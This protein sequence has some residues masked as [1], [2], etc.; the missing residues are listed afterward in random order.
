M[1]DVGLLNPPLHKLPRTTSEK[2]ARMMSNSLRC[3]NPDEILKSYCKEIKCEGICWKERD[4]FTPTV[5]QRDIPKGCVS[6][7]PGWREHRFTGRF[8]SMYILLPLRHA[9][10]VWQ[11]ET[12]DGNFPLPGEFWHLTERRDEMRS[13]AM[14]E[15]EKLST[16]CEEL[17]HQMFDYDVDNPMGPEGATSH[18]V[19]HLKLTGA[20]EYTPQNADLEERTLRSRL[21]GVTAPEDVKE[22]YE[23]YD[24]VVLLKDL[25][26][27]GGID[28]EAIAAGWNGVPKPLPNNIDHARG[29]RKRR[30]R[31][32]LRELKSLED[33]GWSWF[34]DRVG[35]CDGTQ[36]THCGRQD[37]ECILD[38]RHD[39]IGGMQAYGTTEFIEFRLGNVKGGW[40]SAQFLIGK[41]DVEIVVE[42]LGGGGA[43]VHTGKFN[44][45]AEEGNGNKKKAD[46]FFF[47]YKREFVRMRNLWN[48][49]NAKEGEY[50]VRV[51]ISSV[52]QRTNENPILMLTHLYWSV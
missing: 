41:G 16:R 36:N 33:I 15:S 8:L 13:A 37:Y 47:P 17:L 46:A 42:I 10:S 45:L 31:R 28:V 48:D 32:G 27:E 6:W 40:V 9:L 21:V 11:E 26:E 49:P 30:K 51:K 50:S 12:N 2:Q 18:R 19:C 4:D 1:A 5:Q 23:G 43:V 38:G 20:T 35:E 3:L 29:R 24:D 14:D 34:R 44:L 39:G 22:V 52:G 7:H 25:V